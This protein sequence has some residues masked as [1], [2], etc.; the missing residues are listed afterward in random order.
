MT[1]A[2]S[3]AIL[4]LPSQ[5]IMFANKPPGNLIATEGHL[6]SSI[7]QHSIPYLLRDFDPNTCQVQ[8]VAHHGISEYA[9]AFAVPP[10]VRKERMDAGNAIHRL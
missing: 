4:D 8:L 6:T 10:L 9:K 3:F 1:S 5:F 7:S 2:L